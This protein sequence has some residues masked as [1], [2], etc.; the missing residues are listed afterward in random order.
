M[1]REWKLGKDLLEQD[2]LLDGLTFADL[3]TTVQCNCPYPNP[4]SVRQEF[5]DILESQVQDAWSLL[6][7][8]MAAIIQ[9]VK[10]GR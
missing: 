1:T 3:I 7:Q 4:A 6:E 5:R 8:N 2:S 9:K 10:E